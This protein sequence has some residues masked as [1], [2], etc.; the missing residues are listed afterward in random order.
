M[1]K[2]KDVII[3]L[4]VTGLLSSAAFAQQPTTDM[5]AISPESAVVPFVFASENLSTAFGAAGVIKHAG[6]PQASVLGIGLYTTNDSWVGYLAAN[7]YQL[8]GLSQWLFSAEY[9]QGLFQEGIYYLPGE[10]EAATR[11]ITRG[12]EQFA[13]LHIDYVLP[14]G[15]G[16]QGAVAAMGPSRDISWDPRVSGVSSI[17]LTAFNQSHSLAVEQAV[18]EHARGVALQFNWDNRDNGRNSTRGGQSSLTLKYGTA[19]DGNEN[20]QTWELEQSLFV[21]LGQN[22]LFRQQVLAANLYLADT[23]S[24]DEQSDGQW[25]RP[26]AYAGISLGGFER[27]RGYS[28]R[29]FTGRSALLYTLEYRVQPHWQPLQQWPVFNFY[30][31]PW[32]QWVLFAEAGQVSDNFSA[33]ALH[34]DMHWSLGG[35]VRFEVESVVVRA[36]MGVSADS[37]QFWVMVSQPF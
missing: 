37:K 1:K 29:R 16:R 13:K 18:P 14:I 34:D 23:P 6:Q 2:I 33:S 22:Q 15:R 10:T 5:P 28:A 35:G 12:E 26:P 11:V 32:W 27:L 21:P 31:V 30:D 36:E 25:H 7:H 19:S 20:W 3:S 9:Y 8:P 17:R 24:W 4:A